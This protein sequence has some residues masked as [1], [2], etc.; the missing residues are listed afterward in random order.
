MKGQSNNVKADSTSI[1]HETWSS[2]YKF[3]LATVGAAIGLANVWRFPYVVGTSGGSTFVLTYI[4]I[5]LLFV[6]PVVIAEL[7]IG[8]YGR[9][10]MIGSMKKIALDNKSSANWSIIAYLGILA[11]ILIQFFYF[12][13]AGWVLYYFVLSIF[14]GFN[15]INADSSSVLFEELKHNPYALLICQTSLLLIT[16]LI[17]ARGIRKGV[18]KSVSWLLPVLFISLIFFVG[19]GL[20]LGTL[21]DALVFLFAFDIDKLNFEVVQLAMG[22]AFF[23]IGAGLGFIMTYGAYLP[24]E[25]SIGK[26]ALIIILADVGAALLAGLAVYSIVFGFALP[27]DSG[28]GL[29]FV[30]L[31]V[32]FGQMQFGAIFGIVFFG[33]LV[34]AVIPT[35]I[36]GYEQIVC[37]MIELNIGS[38]A[39][40][41][42]LLG[43]IIWF[44]GVPALLSFNYWSDVYILDFVPILAGKNV[45]ELYETIAVIFLIPLCGI[46]IAIFAGWFISDESC[47]K[48]LGS[49][50]RTL[51]LLWKFLL[52]YVAPVCILAIFL[53]NIIDML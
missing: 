9:K 16:G 34:A 27:I 20:Y 42:A 53:T 31:P 3:I 45:F 15:D 21:K 39:K 13:V 40:V 51:Y 11:M 6:L 32:A 18:E 4:V 24:D 49:N 36:S 52:R 2:G 33:A 43:F 46:G 22:Q 48:E 17:V 26:S 28:P 10:S 7:V 23:S 8:R 29:I 44:G 47:Q 19:Y 38:R 50:N 30:A 37:W 12:V 1:K 41:S 35:L 25:V 14:S 5:S